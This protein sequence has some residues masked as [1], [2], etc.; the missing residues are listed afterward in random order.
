M[1]SHITF[2]SFAS[3]IQFCKSW[4]IK[5]NN[6]TEISYKGF[7][8]VHISDSGTRVLVAKKKIEHWIFS[9]L[10]QTKFADCRKQ[11]Q[12]EKKK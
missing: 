6:N 4:K 2:G 11:K 8:S 7:N 1:H 10:H 9:L 12:W 3:E 5:F